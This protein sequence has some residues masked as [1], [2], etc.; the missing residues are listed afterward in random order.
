MTALVTGGAGFLGSHLCTGLPAAG[1]E[2]V[3][4][5]NYFTR[6]RRNLEH[7]LDHP[8]FEPIRHDMCFPLHVEVDRIFNLA[9]PASPIHYQRDPVQTIKMSV[10]GSI[11]MLGL[12]KR[13]LARNL[14]RLGWS[15]RIGFEDGLRETI[16]HFCRELDL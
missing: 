16:A 9:C 1:H 7:V 13:V 14:Q 3:S 10:I 6:S 4:G 2:V 5:D 12:A 11:N 15:P 8:N